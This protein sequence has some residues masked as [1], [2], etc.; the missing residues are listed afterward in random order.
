MERGNSSDLAGVVT[1]RDFLLGAGS[2]AVLGGI[3]GCLGLGDD[4]QQTEELGNE[5]DDNNSGDESAEDGTSG[6]PDGEGNDDDETES[7]DDVAENESEAEVAAEEADDDEN[8]EGESEDDDTTE[9]L[10]REENDDGEGNTTDPDSEHETNDADRENGTA[11]ESHDNETT[12]DPQDQDDS[13]DEADENGSDDGTDED[14][15]KSDQAE[16]DSGEEESDEDVRFEQY[17]IKESPYQVD[18]PANWV[19]DEGDDYVKIHNDD[20]TAWLWIEIREVRTDLDREVRHFRKDFEP[21]PSVEIHA[22]DP[23]T[24]SSGEEGHRFIIEMTERER[25]IFAHELIAQATGYQYRTAVVVS[26]SVYTEEYAQLAE[27]ILATVAL[28]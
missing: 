15:P 19:V 22:D 13:G 28:R 20:E 26:R 8:G 3:A 4:D 16:K 9:D 27:E 17:R 10:D 24:L 2:I 21:D 5:T 1:R 6:D 25:N 18:H 23:V 11:D 7:P 14:D 12:E